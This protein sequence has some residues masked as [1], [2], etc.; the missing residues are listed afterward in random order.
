MKRTIQPVQVYVSSVINGPIEAIW[1][2]VRD[3][4][5]LPAWHPSIARSSIEENRD[6]AAVGCV[7]RI[8][9]KGGEKVR[10]QLLEL[11]DTDYRFTYN[12]LESDFGLLDYVAG[13]S[14]APITDGNRTFAIWSANFKTAA[15][16]E[17]EKKTMVAEGVFQV[18]FDALKA[19]WA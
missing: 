17:T 5:A 15:G 10:E 4:N 9:L 2:L 18:G 19:R 13:F 6:G 7:R 12:I 8:V 1:A 16:Q 11:S 3:F 14:L